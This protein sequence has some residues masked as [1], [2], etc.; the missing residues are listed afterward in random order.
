MSVFDWVSWPSKKLSQIGY[1]AGEE[2]FANAGAAAYVAASKAIALKNRNRPQQTLEDNRKSWL[3][4]NFASL[5]DQVRIVYSADL[6]PSINVLGVK[7][8][9]SAIGQTFGN[10][11]YMNP[12]HKPND[13][14]QLVQLAHEMVHARQYHNRGKSLSKF[15]RDYFRGLYRA[16]FSY[17]KNYMEKDA[18]D[19]NECFETRFLSKISLSE[20]WRSQWT[21]GWSSLMP[22]VL[23]GNPHYLAYKKSDGTAHIDRIRP[24][25]LGVDTIWETAAGQKWTKGWTSFVPFVLNGQPHYLAYK[26]GSGQVAIDRIRGDGQGVDTIWPPEGIEKW[27]TGWTSFVPFLLGGKPHYL[28]YKVGSGQVAIDR[29]RS[30]GQGVD[31]IWPAEGVAKWSKGWTSFVPFVLSGQPH[32]LAYKVATGR[33]NI[34]RIRPNGD[35]VDTLWDGQ[36]SKGWTSMIAFVF[37]GSPHILSYRPGAGYAHID[38]VNP[39]GS[40]TEHIWCDQWTGNWTAFVPF[41]LKGKPHHLAYKA[42][43]G[44]AAIDTIS[45]A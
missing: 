31:T 2:I 10:K 18:Y 21:K 6:V 20:I 9:T 8:K 4:P 19:F 7:L 32:Y 38:R 1:K 3:R 24:D 26:A 43:A 37:N 28:A 35:G 12:K 29:I 22:F 5:V 17:S 27:S 23:N 14:T 13:A 41:Q 45:A 30:D 39:A 44:T 42:N 25:A 36:W 11:I 16:G 33:V 15:G 40:G 34:D